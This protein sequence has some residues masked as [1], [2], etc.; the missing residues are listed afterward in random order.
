MR[1]DVPATDSD[2]SLWVRAMPAAFVLLWATGFVGA[3]YGLPAAPP[4][5]FLFLR[6]VFVLLLLVPI[7]WALRARW[8]AQPAQW[9]HLAVA[10]LLVQAGYLGGVFHAIDRGMSAGLSALIVGLQPV[11]TAVL[12]AAM[13]HERVR[14]VQWGGLVL[15]L[16]GVALV[17]ADKVSVS[18]LT[19]PALAFS[20]LALFSMTIGTVYQKRYCGA[21][22][23]RTGAIIQFVAA[24]LVMLPFALRESRPVVWTP[25]FI[26]AMAWLVLA[27]S[28]VAIGLLALL[29]R[30]GAATKVASLF[31]LVPPCTALF[32]F[33]A[34]RE[35]L[36]PPALLGMAVAVIGVALVVRN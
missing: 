11:L 20:T 19:L 33:A 34:F 21:F 13:L 28:V 35:R 23:L 29:V 17:V 24:A 26:A 1:K 25:T 8:P 10:G 31:Y 12:A 15:G 16:G 14:P 2:Q 3:K 18:G 27:L 22:D 32:A 7:A 4:A 9:M 30:R 36:S 5:S 6:F